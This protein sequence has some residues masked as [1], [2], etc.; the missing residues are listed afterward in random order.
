M[1]NEKEIKEAGITNPWKIFFWEVF[2]F[3]LTLALGLTT[4]FQ[5]NKILEIQRIALTPIS[6]LQFISYFL[7][8]TLF[9]II[10]ISLKK[11]KKGKGFIFKILFVFLVFWGGSITLSLWLPDILVLILM[12][13]LI[14]SWFKFSS[15]FIHDLAVILGIAGIGSSVGLTLNPFVISGL[16]VIFSIYDFIA[17]YKTK[18]MIK[19]AKEMIEAGAIIALICPQRISDFRA[20]LKEVKPGGKFLILG[21]GDVAFPLLLCA[22][23]IREGIFNSLF[24]AIFALFGLSL[25]FF[26]FINQKIRRPIPALPPIA[27]FSIIGFLITLII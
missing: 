17:V 3:S 25:S 9:I 18:H 6:F 14:F 21:G 19:M 20:S 8:A 4:A 10:L 15:I 22:S 5:L 1:E 16:L 2:L 11:F 7:L 26:I 27:L 12:A 23:L 13:I 24:V